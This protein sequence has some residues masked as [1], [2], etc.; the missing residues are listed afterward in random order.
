MGW[1]DLENGFLN[2]WEELK[3]IQ[4]KNTT[5]GLFVNDLCR[6]I[7]SFANVFRF[8]NIFIKIF[9]FLFVFSIDMR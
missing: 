4:M 1:S 2:E 3:K 9:E 6:M 7:E 8:L 5:R